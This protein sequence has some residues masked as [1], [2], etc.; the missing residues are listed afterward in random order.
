MR[1]QRQIV[2]AKQTAKTSEQIA[3]IIP[4]S[5]L[6]YFKWIQF[7]SI[8]LFISYVSV[9]FSQP[10][11]GNGRCFPS[12]TFCV[13]PTQTLHYI[14]FIMNL[15]YEQNWFKVLTSTNKT[16]GRLG[17]EDKQVD[18]PIILIGD[19]QHTNLTMFTSTHKS[20]QF[21][22]IHYQYTCQGVNK[23]REHYQKCQ[24]A[25]GT[26]LMNCFCTEQISNGIIL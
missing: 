23:F 21:F 22:K 11:Q 12:N 9:L 4:S 26:E 1:Y 18:I 7:A 8:S 13:P 15:E 16:K 19:M 6:K 17:L 25:L 10:L 3:H 2:S 5:A 24:Q 20:K 14:S